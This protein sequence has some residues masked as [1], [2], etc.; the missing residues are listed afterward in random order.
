LILSSLLIKVRFQR[1]KAWVVPYM[2][3]RFS[4]RE[5]LRQYDEFNDAK[6]P[7]SL[8]MAPC[9]EIDDESRCNSTLISLMLF[10]P[11]F[12]SVANGPAS[13]GQWRLIVE[14]SSAA[15]LTHAKLFP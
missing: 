8:T 5:K 1:F 13:A 6:G 12:T 9:F 2:R 10:T 14:D 11:R 7:T 3:V 15:V 4:L